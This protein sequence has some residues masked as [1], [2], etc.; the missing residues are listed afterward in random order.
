M[1]FLSPGISLQ[2]L[3]RKQRSL[4]T[5]CM[6]TMTIPASQTG[7][8][9]KRQ[10]LAHEPSATLQGMPSEILQMI[11]IYSCS[12]ELPL[13]CRRF[14]EVLACTQYLKLRVLAQL[15]A[16]S[17]NT[18]FPDVHSI[19]DYKFVTRELMCKACAEGYVN[20]NEIKN[21]VMSKR[22]FMPPYTRE[23]LELVEY[24]T[25]RLASY[26]TAEEAASLLAEDLYAHPDDK[27][28]DGDFDELDDGS[29]TSEERLADVYRS[30]MLDYDS[31]ETFMEAYKKCA[32]TGRFRC[33]IRQKLF[34]LL[35]NYFTQDLYPEAVDMLLSADQYHLV[36]FA[37]RE[38]WIKA[39]DPELLDMVTCRGDAKAIE[40][41]YS[42][43]W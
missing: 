6:A 31:L 33:T 22:L 4:Y 41:L 26:S 23:K 35:V 21:V 7:S 17:S 40:F 34:I 3:K 24:L 11:F 5:T 1:G 42:W 43:S 12:P 37:L 29:I 13:V 19:C 25:A 20:E 16:E 2:G 15:F 9:A 39:T 18:L 10:K 30:A 28:V 36:K 8:Y 14:H 32:K 27:A 38:N